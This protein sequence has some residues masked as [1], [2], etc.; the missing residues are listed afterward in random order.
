MSLLTFR[1]YLA[2]TIFTF[3]RADVSFGH[4]SLI[5]DTSFLRNIL[6][7]A[8]ISL[9]DITFSHYFLSLSYYR[10]MPILPLIS[11]FA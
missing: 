5:T 2:D 11:A 4:I 10:F 1:H 3:S 7:D 8:F 9:P 6:L